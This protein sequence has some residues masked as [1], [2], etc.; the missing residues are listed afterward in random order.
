MDILIGIVL[1]VIFVLCMQ[2]A[3]LIVRDKDVEYRDRKQAEKNFKKF[4]K[5][6]DYKVIGK[7]TGVKRK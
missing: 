3:Y 6:N 2:G 4:M 5:D 7:L 1:A